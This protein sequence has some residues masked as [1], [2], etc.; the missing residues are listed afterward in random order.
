MS[1]KSELSNSHLTRAF[2]NLKCV[3]MKTK[4]MIESG[5]DVAVIFIVFI[6]T[7]ALAVLI[8]KLLFKLL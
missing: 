3:R 5:E 4:K 2:Q 7:A 1:G 6:S 8:G